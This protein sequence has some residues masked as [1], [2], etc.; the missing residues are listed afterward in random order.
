LVYAFAA[1]RVRV[2]D[3]LRRADRIDT[4]VTTARRPPAC[5]R[6][7]EPEKSATFPEMLGMAHGNSHWVFGYGSLIWR[8]GFTS[9]SQQQATMP[10]VH[11]RLCVYSYRHRGTEAQPGL[12]FGLVHGG[13]CRGMAFEVPEA[14]WEGAHAYLSEREMDRGVYREATRTMVLADGRR[15]EGLVFLVDEKHAQFAGKL[16]VEEQVRLVRIGVGESGPNPEYVLET[17]RY[18]QAL[19]IRDRAL[20]EVVSALRV[21]LP[22]AETA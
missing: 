8:P 11:R 10:G 18:L 3:A 4:N 22:V 19:G 2:C 21:D 20:D 1:L 13:S 5:G 12:V 14:E 17:A 15:V 6:S 9:I 16:T 7:F